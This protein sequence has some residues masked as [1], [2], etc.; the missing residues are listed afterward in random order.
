[1]RKIPRQLSVVHVVPIYRDMEI[2]HVTHHEREREKVSRTTTLRLNFGNK[3]ILTF[4]QCF[5]IDQSLN[6]SDHYFLTYIRV[7]FGDRDFNDS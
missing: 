6:F 4:F 2:S 1:M 7:T 3:L 5:I